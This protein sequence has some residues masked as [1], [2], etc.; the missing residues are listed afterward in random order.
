MK[1]SALVVSLFLLPLALLPVSGQDVG[2]VVIERVV[3]A[4]DSVTEL[5]GIAALDG[6]SAGLSFPDSEASFVWLEALNR[7]LDGDPSAGPAAE[8]RMTEIPGRPGRYELTVRLPG[9]MGALDAVPLPGETLALGARPVSSRP[10]S[11]LSFATGGLRMASPASMYRQGGRELRVGM[12]AGLSDGMLFGLPSFAVGRIFD[13]GGDVAAY[14]AFQAA[15][16]YERARSGM[17]DKN[18]L[19]DLAFGFIGAAPFPWR[20]G[21][22]SI[23]S[24]NVAER[25]GAE[26][27]LSAEPLSFGDLP[28]HLYANV[29]ASY[30]AGTT[31]SS[32]EGTILFT[33]GQMSWVEGLPEGLFATADAR[34]AIDLN[35]VEPSGSVAAD[36]RWAE[37]FGESLGM[38]AIL[39][40]LFMD[41]ENPDWAGKI[42]GVSDSQKPVSGYAGLLWRLD[43][44]LTL[45]RGTLLLDRSLPIHLTVAAISDGAIML[46]GT[47]EFGAPGTFFAT[48]GAELQMTLDSRRTDFMRISAAWDLSDILNGTASSLTED[49]L[50]LVAAVGVFF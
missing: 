5:Q 32:L 16:G 46:S 15:I 18:I 2:S 26:F 45:A 11:G 34:G 40:G 7:E 47:R 44:L 13:D 50:E 8:A 38:D 27:T 43:A 24:L 35:L 49:D 37:R 14:A 41:A 6:I 42:R 17:S 25:A 1:P 10:L 12:E 3:W 20:L 33:V 9:R 30:S 23:T 29:M 39:S 19:V 22:K 4:C 36:L 28:M 21:A 31:R 48:A